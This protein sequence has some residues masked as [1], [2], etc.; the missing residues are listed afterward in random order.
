VSDGWADERVEWLDAASADGIRIG[1]LGARIVV[2]WAGLGRLSSSSS[3]SD[4]SFTAAA[5]ANGATFEKFRSTSLLA[6]RRYLAG[7]L[8]LHA[9]AV[10][11]PGGAVVLV[12]DSGMGKSTTAM[13][14]VERHGG[15]FLAD[16]I[17]PI[18]W[19]DDSTPVVSPVDD[20]F[21]LNG[22]A[23]AWFGVR[24]PANEKSACSPRARSIAPEQLQAIVH[25]VFDDACE[26]ADLQPITGQAAFTVLSAAHV[27]YS[28][29]GDEEALRN[30]A[31]RARLAQ[32]T[33]VLR[34]RRG[35]SLETLACAARLL[36]ERLSGR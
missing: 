5:G 26:S 35:R 28:T 13:A 19:N 25:L 14:L 27:C 20:S 22:D 17:V 8:S 9:S 15:T 1:R 33:K 16:D 36:G 34:L 12:G 7:K 3:G 21:W 24:A 18:D 31:A 29:G 2:E 23:S 4:T 10:G 30:F 6:C 32:S 11:L